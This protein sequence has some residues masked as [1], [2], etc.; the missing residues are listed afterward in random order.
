MR[1]LVA[2]ILC[3]LLAL[4]HTRL[5]WDEDSGYVYAQTQ[6]QE[7]EALKAKNEQIRLVN[8]KLVA[9]LKDLHEGTTILEDHARN[10]LGMLKPNEVLI[11]FR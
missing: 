11:V 5:W 2:V 7:L 8:S 6:K 4:I 10:E 9:E 3:C 1:F